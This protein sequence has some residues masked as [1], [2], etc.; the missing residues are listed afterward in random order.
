MNGSAPNSPATGSQICVRQNARPNFV[1]D[2]IDS[3]VSTT[4]ML[5]TMT[6]R[7]RAKAPVPILKARSL[8][9][10]RDFMSAPPVA[11]TYDTL[12][13]AIAASSSFTTASGSG[14]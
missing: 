5:T 11:D 1:I 13:F 6:S 12:I 8:R 14:A 9:L 3:R 4:A 10:T 7:N 2:S